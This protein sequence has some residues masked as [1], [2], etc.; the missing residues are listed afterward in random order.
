[1][2]AI[3]PIWTLKCCACVRM[4]HCKGKADSFRTVYVCTLWLWVSFASTIPNLLYGGGSLEMTCLISLLS[5][6]IST[7][8]LSH[9][10]FFCAI[11]TALKWV[12]NNFSLALIVMQ[13]PTTMY[14]SIVISRAI[15]TP[16]HC[17]ETMT[18]LGGIIIGK[19]SFFLPSGFGCYGSFCQQMWSIPFFFFW[20]AF[21]TN[22][23]I[24]QTC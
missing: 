17:L 2:A 16:I 6:E 3:L 22:F 11:Y 21:V 10:H 4:C 7:F 15:F 19:L 9:L 20:E 13:T 12:L 5:F 24:T 14:R 8:H 1:M 23:F 18:K